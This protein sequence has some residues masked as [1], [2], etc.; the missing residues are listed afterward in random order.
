MRDFIAY[1]Y[2]Y[3]AKPV[4]FKFD[5]ED[6]HDR[7]VMV[8]KLLGKL[9]PAR[10][11]TKKIFTY[12]DSILAQDVCGLH[13]SNPIGLSA[14]F[15]KNA[16]LTQIMSAIG[17][18]FEEVGSVTGKLCAGNPKPR[19]WRVPEQKGIR[20]YYGL[21][22]DGC[23]VIADRLAHTRRIEKDFQLGISVAMTN[24][25]ANL[26]IDNAVRDYQKAFRT[27]EPHAD[28]LTINI[29][30]PNTLGGQPFTDPLK[31]EKL[32]S[33]LEEDGALRRAPSK[34]IFIK[35]SPDMSMEQVDAVL[36]VLQ[37]H[38]VHGI[39]CTNLTKKKEVKGGYSGKM[40]QE[41]SDKLLAHIYRSCGS[42]FVLVG[43]GGVFS[44]EDAY[45]KI[46]LG[47]TLIQ[48]ITGMIY[49]GPQV[50]GTIN[51][52]LATLLRRDGF[53]HISQAIGIDNR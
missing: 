46:R 10:Y 47:A 26:D 4:L 15:D 5:P 35:M 6:V 29:S 18:A 53:T 1:I 30:C 12:E 16:E 38:R 50:V 14:G 48:M 33:A 19:L 31:L 37:V 52:D 20:V 42:R 36:A 23:E 28:Y 21:K 9:T 44:A 39:I 25:E 49:E 7:M 27:M 51:R 11:I 45:R 8:G 3:L 40:V 2:K 17:F 13:F 34:P 24:C 22:N 43:C 32:L 41:Q